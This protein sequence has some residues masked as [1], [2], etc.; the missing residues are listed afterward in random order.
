L[1]FGLQRRAALRA[2]F[3]ASPGPAKG[4]YRLSGFENLKAGANG[5][6]VIDAWRDCWMS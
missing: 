1:P 2:R 5:D 6:K 3:A 4:L